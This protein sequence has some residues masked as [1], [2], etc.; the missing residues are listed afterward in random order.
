MVRRARLGHVMV[1][2]ALLVLPLD[3][4]GPVGTSRSHARTSRS[5]EIYRER[6][7]GL[8]ACCRVKYGQGRTQLTAC[9]PTEPCR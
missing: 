1:A 9:R 4:A 5:I 6:L 2:L 8:T 3:A 7:H